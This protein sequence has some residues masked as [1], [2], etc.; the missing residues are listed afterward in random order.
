MTLSSAELKAIID[1]R[2]G[3][4]IAM[5]RRL[6]GEACDNLR[7]RPDWSP[8]RDIDV[9]ACGASMAQ[10]CARLAA[11]ALEGEGRAEE[12]L[13]RVIR[14]AFD[15]A[16]TGFGIDTIERSVAREFY[17]NEVLGRWVLDLDPY[18][19]RALEARALAKVSLLERLRAAE[20]RVAELEAGR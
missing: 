6:Q 20:A 7:R 1:Q 14:D 10:H 15:A 19:E 17:A 11:D 18:Q 8:A 4:R 5:F 16:L 9:C 13:L 2:R 12:F 3:E